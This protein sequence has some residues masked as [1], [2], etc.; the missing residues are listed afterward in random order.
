MMA[1]VMKTEV[2]AGSLMPICSK[3][4]FS[5]IYMSYQFL[6]IP[7]EVGYDNYSNERYFEASLPTMTSCMPIMIP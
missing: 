1:S 3:E 6:T 2:L 5:K 4:Y 7:S